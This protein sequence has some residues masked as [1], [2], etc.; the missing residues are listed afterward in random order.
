MH[1]L[2][3]A[4]L[5]SAVVGATPPAQCALRCA[6]RHRFH[7]CC[8]H[9]LGRYH[10]GAKARRGPHS[11]GARCRVTAL[12]SGLPQSRVCTHAGRW[13][14]RWP[15]R[16]LKR[17]RQEEGKSDRPLSRERRL[18][19][20]LLIWH[21]ARPYGRDCRHSIPIFATIVFTGR[22]MSRPFCVASRFHQYPRFCIHAV[23]S[24]A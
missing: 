20:L 24:F 22:L 23:F 8:T 3:H 21:G 6:V 16:R 7:R 1:R 14:R 13:R 15:E 2:A 10:P 9:T 5:R 18:R 12:D 11:T 4:A 17:S 19:V